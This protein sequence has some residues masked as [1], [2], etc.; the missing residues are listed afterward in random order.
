MGQQRHHQAHGFC[1]GP[2]TREGRAFG[3]AERLA[4]RRTDKA[5]LLARVDANVALADLSSGGARHIGAACCRGVHACLLRV[6]LGNVRR[7][8]CLDPHFHCKRTVPR[9]SV[10]LPNVRNR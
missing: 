1:R 7:G 9:F 10:E 5:L 2:Q 3:G 6:T 8:V 4:A